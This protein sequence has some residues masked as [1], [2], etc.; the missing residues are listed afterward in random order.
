M[1]PCS[2]VDGQW[3]FGST[4]YLIVESRAAIHM[5]WICRY[6]MRKGAAYFFFR[7]LLKSRRR[8]LGVVRQEQYRKRNANI[9]EERFPLFRLWCNVRF[10]FIFVRAVAKFWA[11]LSCT[12][13]ANLVWTR[14]LCV[15]HRWWTSW[16]EVVT[17]VI[18]VYRM[19]SSNSGTDTDCCDWDS[20]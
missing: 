19:S 3:R 6:V 15:Y 1:T 13:A 18:R 9:I 14:R 12:P 20:L 16:A 2:L 4:C 11:I 7:S 10:C 17:V 8:P 5:W